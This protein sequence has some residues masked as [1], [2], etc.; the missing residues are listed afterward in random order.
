[1][2]HGDCVESFQKSTQ[3][4]HVSVWTPLSRVAAHV[5]NSKRT[6][7][8]VFCACLEWYPRYLEDNN[9]KGYEARDFQGVYFETKKQVG[10]EMV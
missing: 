3:F 2:V 6:H 10:I 4:E 1:M 7:R 8:C 9:R 5:Q